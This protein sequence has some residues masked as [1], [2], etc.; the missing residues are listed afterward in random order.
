MSEKDERTATPTPAET[1]FGAVPRR[2]F[3]KYL[4]AAFATA[5][6]PEALSACSNLGGS[7][8]PAVGSVAEEV[9]FTSV[10]MLWVTR[11]TDGLSL[12][13]QFSGLVAD[14]NHN[15]NLASGTTAGQR[16]HRDHVPAAARDRRRGPR[17]RE[18]HTPAQLLR[19]RDES[20]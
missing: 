15:L 11:K 4:A 8:S 6:L 13:F 14:A 18:P 16:V 10:A 20:N 9:N 5:A 19:I 3:L 2:G 17:R 7:A 1:L 12:G